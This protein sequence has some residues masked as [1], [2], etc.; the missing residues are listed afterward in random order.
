METSRRPRR[1]RPWCFPGRVRV[2]GSRVHEAL[3]CS[4][5]LQGGPDCAGSVSLMGVGNCPARPSPLAERGFRVG[6][7]SVTSADPDRCRSR[8]RSKAPATSRCRTSAQFREAALWK[9]VSLWYPVAK[10]IV[11]DKREAAVSAPTQRLWHNISHWPSFSLRIGHEPVAEPQTPDTNAFRMRDC[12][13]CGPTAEA[14]QAGERDR[15]DQFRGRGD[16]KRRSRRIRRLTDPRPT[17][18]ASR[19]SAPAGLRA[20]A[21]RSLLAGPQGRQRGEGGEA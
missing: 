7:P 18:F 21:G 4:P 12:D 5:H 14:L 17:R 3:T 6:G 13:D 10:G 16:Y 2:A 20:N 15:E 1:G 9:A 19:Y 11:L 8:K